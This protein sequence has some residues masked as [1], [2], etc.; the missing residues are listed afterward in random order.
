MLAL[1]L[2]TLEPVGDGLVDFKLFTKKSTSYLVYL[3]YPMLINHPPSPTPKLSYQ[4]SSAFSFLLENIF[5]MKQSTNF[6]KIWTF[7]HPTVRFIVV[8][9]I[10]VCVK[11]GHTGI[12]SAY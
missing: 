12:T 8:Q 6:G 4:L 10:Y 5:Q 1:N 2:P 9:Y 7:D 11:S 3:Y